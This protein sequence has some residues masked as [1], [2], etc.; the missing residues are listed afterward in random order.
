MTRQE[1]INKSSSYIK[2][3]QY[4][5]PNIFTEW[6]FKD[7]QYHAWCG[8]FIDYVIKHDL[9][10]NFL[11]SC[12]NFAGCGSIVDWAKKMG[13]WNTNFKKAQKGDLVMYNWYPEKKDH[14]S[15]IGIVE[16]VKT[17]TIIS[18]EGNT[19]NNKYKDNCVS[20]KERKK[21]Y[22]AG[23]ILLPYKEEDMFKIGDKVEALEDVK[24]YTTVEQKESLYTIKKGEVALVKLTYNN[25]FI[26]LADIET[27][28]YFPSGWTKELSK[29]KLYEVDYKKLY[30]EE[31]VKNKILQDK[32][33]KAIEDLK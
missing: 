7:K 24:L 13:Y 3:E 20:R 28:I 29:F 8:V 9:K 19:S 6:Y 1:L 26:C 33:N 30:E 17:N 2:E 4:S 12:S 22:I 21:K 14:Y 5:N 31:L 32:I 15:H 18:I 23:V 27:E 25:T 11:D 10:C 16:Q